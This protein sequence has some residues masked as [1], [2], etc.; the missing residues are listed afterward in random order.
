MKHII[1]AGVLLKLGGYDLFRSFV[2]FLKFPFNSKF[3]WIYISLVTQNQNEF[4]SS[5][6]NKK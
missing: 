4:S 5:Q 6:P 3:I 2:R 1:L